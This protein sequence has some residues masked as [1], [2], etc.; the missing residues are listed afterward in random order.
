MWYSEAC[1]EQRMFSCDEGSWNVLLAA[2]H[3]GLR[4]RAAWQPFLGAM[5]QHPCPRATFRRSCSNDSLLDF[6]G[7][8]EFNQCHEAGLGQSP[9][10]NRIVPAVL[11]WKLEQNRWL[12]LLE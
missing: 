9:Q 11:A 12:H 7:K 2:V 8:A 3:G 1:A 10:L 6:V 5:G 4:L